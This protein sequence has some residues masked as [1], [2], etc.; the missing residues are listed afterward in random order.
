M[1]ASNSHCRQNHEIAYEVD[2]ASEKDNVESS[3]QKVC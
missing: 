1:K 2:M 3:S